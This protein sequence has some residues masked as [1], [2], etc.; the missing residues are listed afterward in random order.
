VS[1]RI[2]NWADIREL[3]LMSIG[4]DKGAWWADPDF[5]SELWMLKRSGKTTGETAGTLRRMILEATAWLVAGGL[6]EKIDC[7]AERTGRNEITYTVT[8]YRGNGDNTLITEVWN[9]L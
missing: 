5:G 7:A 1:I 4:T 3:A 9:A 6:A 8:V 2:E